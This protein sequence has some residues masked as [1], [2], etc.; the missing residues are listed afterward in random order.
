MT[1]V[2][3][4][5]CNEP[6]GNVLVIY[7][8]MDWPLKSTVIDHLHCFKNHSAGRVFYLNLPIA[9][10]PR[11]I[12][13]LKWDV[14]VYH[15][16]FLS[17]RWL[18]E[19]FDRNCKAAAPLRDLGPM[20]VAL[21]QDDFIYADLLSEFISKFRVENVLS[22]IPETEVAA[23]YPSVDRAGTKFGQVLTGYLSD[24]TL[25]RIGRILD[26]SNVR[27][28]DIGYR[29]WEGAPWLGRH[30]MLKREI[31]EVV[32]AAAPRLGLVADCSTRAEDTFFGDDW[33]R[34]LAR[35]RFVLGVEGGASIVD[36]DGQIGRAHV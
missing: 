19:L 8:L 28:I 30:G 5:A 2:G 7:S 4:K 14:V 31:S 1:P 33:F 35:C 13:R 6:S 26:E 10:P 22:V 36:R 24:D 11:W 18:P 17:T 3:R 27:Q 12:R 23:V 21:P 20:S 25:S 34:F 9:P 16:S 29:A 15:T 32:M